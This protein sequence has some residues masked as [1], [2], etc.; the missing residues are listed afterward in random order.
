[1]YRTELNNL[2]VWGCKAF[3]HIQ[4]NKRAKLDPHMVPAVFI[5]YPDGYKGWKF[6]D[7]A[8]KRTIISER[9]DFDK[10]CF[11]L[12]KLPSPS[13]TLPSPAPPV[14][15]G[16]SPAVPDSPSVPSVVPL[17]LDA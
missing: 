6:W 3:V 14:A 17:L 15:S 12:S 1:M 7:P 16:P 13:P 5:G 11:P 2:C 8:T 10:F 9:A 4:R